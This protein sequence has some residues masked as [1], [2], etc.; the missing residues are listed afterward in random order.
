MSPF[1]CKEGENW[2]KITEPVKLN[3]KVAEY[4]YWQ[5]AE[6]SPVPEDPDRKLHLTLNS[7]KSTL[8]LEKGKSFDGQIGIV[9]ETDFSIWGEVGC[10]PLVKVIYS[11]YPIK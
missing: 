6:A 2:K 4:T 10:E 1:Y 5:V 7:P 8:R 11:K 3:K 9:S